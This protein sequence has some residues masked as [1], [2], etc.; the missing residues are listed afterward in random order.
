MPFVIITPMY[1]PTRREKCFLYIFVFSPRYAWRRQAF[2][3]GLT[4][5]FQRLGKRWKKFLKIFQV[6]ALRPLKAVSYFCCFTKRSKSSF[7]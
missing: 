4:S 1:P 7:C 2:V 6:S 5:W 3:N